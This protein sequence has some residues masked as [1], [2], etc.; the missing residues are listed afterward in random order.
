MDLSRCNSLI[1]KQFIMNAQQAAIA[2]ARRKSKPDQ[3]LLALQRKTILRMNTAAGKVD[4]ID[5]TTKDTN[6]MTEKQI[7]RARAA[8]KLAANV[9]ETT[10]ALEQQLMSTLTGVA[11]KVD[12]IDETTKDTNTV[13]KSNQEMLTLLVQEP[14]KMAQ[15][16]ADA[17]TK[18]EL[19]GKK[20]KEL[21]RQIHVLRKKN[22]E[23][24]KQT[25]SRD[26]RVMINRFLV[27]SIL[28]LTLFV[29]PICHGEQL[30]AYELCILERVKGSGIY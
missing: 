25:F 24:A 12:D 23:Q 1:P 27:F 5:E 3:E 7:A 21:K 11:G 8:R 16:L 10:V 9:S 14:A 28:N 18:V 26:M 2:R 22:A 4:G 19:T 29:I 20:N 13:A 15:N 17:R 6:R 30:N